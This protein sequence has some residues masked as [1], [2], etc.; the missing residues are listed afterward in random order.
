MTLLSD[1]EKS[2]DDVQCLYV[3][4]AALGREADE[5]KEKKRGRKR[6]LLKL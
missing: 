3:P 2:T 5:E 4:G 6:T 1:V